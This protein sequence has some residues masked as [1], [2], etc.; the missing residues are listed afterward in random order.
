VGFMIT[1]LETVEVV[2]LFLVT[3]MDGVSGG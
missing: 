2:H 3:L 1:N